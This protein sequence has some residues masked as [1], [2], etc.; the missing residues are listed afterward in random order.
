MLVK[1]LEDKENGRKWEI[2]KDGEN[3][4]SYRYYEYFKECGWRKYGEDKN[5]SK[6]AIEWEFDIK[7]A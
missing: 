4:Y 3:D 6:E 1:V 7:V 5:Y 2:Y